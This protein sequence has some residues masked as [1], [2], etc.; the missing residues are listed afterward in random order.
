MGPFGFIGNILSEQIAVC[1]TL[2]VMYGRVRLCHLAATA[3][4]IY[5]A[6]W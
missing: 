1:L 4:D 5:V 3:Y 6:L 2:C